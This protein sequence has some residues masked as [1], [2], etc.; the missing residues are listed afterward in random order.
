M[1]A[2]EASSSC[3]VSLWLLTSPWCLSLPQFCAVMTDFFWA[4][5][6]S[7]TAA[8]RCVCFCPYLPSLLPLLSIFQSVSEC[9]STLGFLA[10]LY[11]F[12]GCSVHGW[13]YGRSY[14]YMD[15]FLSKFIYKNLSLRS[16]TFRLFIK[17]YFTREIF[18]CTVFFFLMIFPHRLGRGKL[19]LLNKWNVHCKTQVCFDFLIV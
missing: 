13:Q 9:L 14:L 1:P 7:L 10:V 6:C 17:R 19:W 18:S 16:G 11:S 5:L 3:P 8:V 2:P 12:E 15:P 4:G